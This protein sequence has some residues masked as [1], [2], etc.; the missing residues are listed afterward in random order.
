MMHPC[1]RWF[2]SLSLKRAEATKVIKLVTDC[3]KTSCYVNRI[4]H[5]DPLTVTTTRRHYVTSK[6]S[7]TKK[8][9][10]SCGCSSTDTDYS[11]LLMSEACLVPKKQQALWTNHTVNNTTQFRNTTS[12]NIS[13]KFSNTNEKISE[14]P[15]GLF[16]WLGSDEI[17]SLSPTT[18]TTNQLPLLLPVPQSS[19]PNVTTVDSIVE[20]V[21]KHYESVSHDT[22]IGGMGENDPGVWF[23]I[24]SNS[25]VDTI[26]YSNMI[27]ESINL[28]KEHRHGVPFGVYT[29]GRTLKS[30]DSDEDIAELI[31]TIDMIHIS[32]FGST[33]EQYMSYTGIETIKDARNAFGQVCSM[34]STV[35]EMYSDGRSGVKII[36]GIVQSPSTTASAR[37]LAHSLGAIDVQVF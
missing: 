7:H 26:E 14:T 13:R 11:R 37:D 20:A 36:A 2:S 9:N 10:N 15:Q 18:A 16:L 21:H 8:S 32:L 24:P 17:G 5:Y 6:Y 3:S 29:T 34:I 27:V 30:I 28:I 1:S 12:F 35:S 4:N 31:E 23:A 33:P 19:V 22:Y 25:I